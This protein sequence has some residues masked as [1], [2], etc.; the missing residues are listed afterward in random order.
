MPQQFGFH[1]RS[2]LTL[3]L[4]CLIP[5]PARASG[6]VPSSEFT[7]LTVSD[8]A[9]LRRALAEAG[10]GTTIRIAPGTYRGGLSARGLRG[11]PGRPIILRAADPERPPVIEGGGSGLHLSDPAHVELHDLVV[12]GA[13][14][15]GINIDDGGSLDTPAHHVVLR[16]LVV[17]DVGP[18]GQPGRHQAL[19]RGR[20][21]GRGLH[22][23]ALGQ[24]G[25]GHRHGRLP[26]GR[27]RSAAPS[28]TATG[29]ATTACR[30][31]AAAARSRSAAAGSSTPGSGRSTSAAAPA[32]PTSG[33]APQGYEAKD[34]TVEDCTFVGSL[35]PVAFVGVDGA[36]GAAQHDLPA[37]AVG[38]AH[39]PGEPAAGLRPLPQRPVHRQPHRLPLRRDG[40]CR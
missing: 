18:D 21:P 5:L 22:R 37:P 30:P 34:I 28:G 17:R 9:Q 35:A 38:P 4:A 20:L 39:P 24:P 12:T 29:R 6:P 11:E 23:R 10:P 14:G 26:P 25:L 15:N 2:G 8:T 3:V 7:T 40:R 16:G 1:R 27:G 33:P 36:D 32:W 13:E 31:R 19:R